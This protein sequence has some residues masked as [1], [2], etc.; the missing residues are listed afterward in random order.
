MIDWYEQDGTTHTRCGGRH[1]PLC[2]AGEMPDPA[3]SLTDRQAAG[4]YLLS[5]SG[6]F[7]EKNVHESA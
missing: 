4:K 7:K 1:L 5:A 3:R 6:N 2:A